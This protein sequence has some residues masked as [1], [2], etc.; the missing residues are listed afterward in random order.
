M[1]CTGRCPPAEGTPYLLLRP[2]WCHPVPPQHVVGALR[3]PGV[4]EAAA[5][6][7]AGAPRG[8]PEK[9]PSQPSRFL[10]GRARQRGLRFHR[11]QFPC[12]AVLLCRR[13]TAGGH[14]QW[15][16]AP[17]PALHAEL[18]R[19]PPVTLGL[20]SPK[21]QQSVQPA[22]RVPGLHLQA[23]FCNHSGR[24]Q[25]RT[26]C[27]RRAGPCLSPHLGGHSLDTRPAVSE[28]SS[29]EW[30]PGCRAVYLQ[31]LGVSFLGKGLVLAGAPRVRGLLRCP[32]QKHL[33][34]SGNLKFKQTATRREEGR[35]NGPGPS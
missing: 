21:E 13:S 9:L 16:R 4:S 26:S 14:W 11:A 6:A 15:G 17:Y 18:G 23:L 35:G 22:L 19:R 8:P 2:G 20:P 10:Q 5:R 29:A 28:E 25:P 27:A 7:D 24:G 34:S 3:S 1:T 32:S 30:G 33:P 12:P 31:V